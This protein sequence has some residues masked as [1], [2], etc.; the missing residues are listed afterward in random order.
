MTDSVDSESILQ[1][2]QVTN[3]EPPIALGYLKVADGNVEQAVSLFLENG[4]APLDMDSSSTSV[5][6]SGPLAPT[7]RRSGKRPSPYATD[8]AP[9]SVGEGV[10]AP[11]AP[12]REVLVGDG[13]TFDASDVYAHRG[14]TNPHR[15]VFDQLPRATTAQ[16]AFRDF[17]AE[18]SALQQGTSPTSESRKINRL[19]D[20]FRPPFDLIRAMD[21]DK[22]REVAKGEHKWLMVNIQKVSEFACQVLNR[23]LWSDTAVKQVVQENFVFLQYGNDSVDGTRYTAFYPVQR[24]PHIAIIDPRTGERVKVWDQPLTPA[25]FLQEI[26]DFLDSSTWLQQTTIDSK[27]QRLPESSVDISNMTE[28][29]QLDAT[30]R[31]SLAENQTSTATSTTASPGPSKQ[32]GTT[33]VPSSPVPSE[34]DQDY[35]QTNELEAKYHSIPAD[36]GTEPPTSASETTRIQFR[37]PDGS[38]VIRRFAKQALVKDLVAFIKAK[39]PCAEEEVVNI[40]YHRENLL[41]KIHLTIAEAGL[42]NAS[43][44]V[45]A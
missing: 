3:A 28:E 9:E 26:T 5:D 8:S 21:F 7:R 42:Q 18:T 38:R 23:D 12:R 20:L 25:D 32:P 34:V 43:I 1:F 15:S 11:L 44:T 14:P 40:L 17:A 24:Y 30:I 27:R 31:A 13:A 6:S 33:A 22:A 39:V 41:D 35:D 4:G 29:E 45:D 37:L 2:C 19:A 10:R 36:E 16:E